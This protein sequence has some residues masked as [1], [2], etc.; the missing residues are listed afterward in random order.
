MVTKNGTSSND[1]LVGGNNTADIINGFG[2]NDTL[3]GLGQADALNGG[4]G[5]DALIGGA[6]ADTLDGGAGTDEI[7]YSSD[8]GTRGVTVNL[9]A[10]TAIDTFGTPDLIRGIERIYGSNR[11]DV[12]TGRDG[13]GDLLFGRGGN[14]AI[15]GGSGNDTLV[16]GAGKD[17]LDGGTGASDQVAYFLEG[18]T[19][20]VTV[21]LSAG[22]AIDTFGNADVLIGIEKVYGSNADDVFLGDTRDNLILGRSGADNLNGAGGA[23]TLVG[24]AGADTINGGDGLDQLAYFLE[25]GTRGISVNLNTGLAYDTFGDLDTLINVEY[26]FATD[27]DDTLIGSNR[28]KNDRLFGRDGNDVIDGLDGDNLI[29]TGAGNDT[30]RVGTTV[31]D[32]RDTVVIDGRGTKT[33]TGTGSEGTRYGHHIVFRTDSAVTV[34]LAT[35]IATSEGMRTDFSGALYFLEVNGSAYD[36]LLTGGN[37]RHQELEWYVGF[38]GNDTING[39][40]GTGDTVVYDDEVLIGQVNYATGLLERGTQG[41]IVNLSTGVATDTFGDTDTLINIDQ[42]RGTS[43]VDRI[44][45]SA[46]NNDFWGLRGADIFDGGAGDDFV[47]Y[48]EDY[49]AE[50]GDN[51]IVAD[52]AAGEVIDGFG[53]VD[54]LTS[55]EGVHGTDF[56]DAIR[57]NGAENRLVAYAGNDTVSGAGGDD[58]ILAGEGN[59]VINGGAGDDEIWGEEGNDTIDGAGGRDVARYL[60][61]TGPVNGNL[62]T[63]VVRDGHGTTD[64]LINVEDLHAS[65]NNDSVVG[66]SAENRLF[67]FGGNDTILGQGGEDVILGGEGADSLSGGAGDDEI[68]GE[69]GNDTIDGGD[70]SDLVRYREDARGVTVNLATDTAT[71]GSGA[72]DTMRNIENVHGSDHADAITGNA[73]DNRLFGFSGADSIAGGAGDDILLGGDGSDSLSGG[74]GNDQLWGE[75][76]TDTLD[77]GAGDGDVVRY[78]NSTAAVEVDL[79]AGTASDGLGY[80]DTLLNIEYAHGSDFGDLLRGNS[81]AN[82]LFG[83]DG[84]DTLIGGEGDGDL[85]SGGAGGDTYIYHAGDGRDTFNDLGETSGGADTVIIEGYTVENA[86]I[87]KQG[88]DALLI[89]FGTTNDSVALSFSYAGTHAGAI[90]Q[91]V[92]A[93]G[94]S[95]TIAQLKARIGTAL[96]QARNA[97]TNGDDALSVTADNT[98]VDGLAGDDTIAGRSSDDMLTGGAGNDVLR[99][100]AGDDTLEGGAGNDNMTGGDG[101][102]LFVLGTRMGSDTVRDF[103]FGKDGLDVSGLS[104]AQVSEIVTT[105][106]AG[107]Q[108]VVLP[109]GG[110]ITLLG[111]IGA[112][113]DNLVVTGAATED[114]TLT[115]TL[116]GATDLYGQ[117]PSNVTYQWQ[118]DGQ[119]ISGATGDSYVLTQADT[120]SQITVRVA[121]DGNAL[122]SAPTAA[123]ENLNDAPLGA[124]VI[125]GTVTEDQTLS[126]ST[127]DISDEDGLGTFSYHWVR[128]GLP[129]ESAVGPEYT[130]TQED[131]GNFVTVEITY[132]DG[133]GKA[134]KLVSNQSGPVANVNDPA[135]GS[136]ILNGDLLLGETLTLDPA[137]ADDD[138]I[139]TISYQW[140]H[141]GVAVSG[142]TGTSYTLGAADVEKQLSVRGTFTD[143]YG[144]AEQVRSSTV[145]LLR[146]ATAVEPEEPEEPVMSE[147]PDTGLRLFGDAGDNTLRG[148]EGNDRLSGAGGNDRLLGNGGADTLLGGDGADTLNGGDGNDEITGGA[149]END[150]RDVIFG[151]NGN[152]LIDAGY[153]NDNISGGNGNDTIAG[154]FGSDTVEGQGGDDVLTGSAFGDEIYGNGGDDFI[155]GGFGYDRVNGGAGAD[156][157]YHLGIADHGSDWIQ[158]YSSAEGDVLYYGG[159]ATAQQFLVQRT[160]TPNAGAGNVEEVFITHRPSGNLLWALI[161][162]DGEAELNIRIGT[163]VFDLLA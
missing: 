70:G 144:T 149:S 7:L 116:N 59:D 22:T 130:L 152:D 57:G 157:F 54:Q 96:V 15:N 24:G 58:I 108:E 27:L 25:T 33:I 98:T 41:A 36:D 68:W 20:G 10:G 105:T 82:N 81:Q 4:P 66:S 11:N 136:L 18:G 134:E 117:A 151:G 97:A 8:G 119:A 78:L 46:E 86:S 1:S 32:A 12:I 71:D 127:A 118:R 35:G 31:E 60:K 128:G 84:N 90:E 61:A 73:D 49:L 154:G 80:T 106:V 55:I 159:Q 141:D 156:Q 122:T 138:G 107:G 133:Q 47:H 112:G 142:Q 162:G 5:N 53:S 139:G 42:V 56:A 48:G 37:L 163:D 160:N 155:N 153:G 121:Y 143:G 104:T 30:V 110:S 52:L 72:T 140:Y 158:D 87:M 23:D 88:A 126:V 125:N 34:N 75:I 102:D 65:S 26:V 79:L 100:G 21:D 28:I 137:I 38:Q 74:D 145:K 77:G 76:G 67:G 62:T 113:A 150:R 114:A 14:D 89:D 135:T 115:V 120:G 69:A 99:G 6:G 39:G 51:G 40:T 83:Y 93:D 3:I 2:G 17:T 101:A 29:F 123:I 103:E 95:F 63:G 85:L 13:A 109:D 161:D 45:G 91:V 129:I 148:E 19:R 16:G 50:G 44:T 146:T 147:G 94:Q 131:V 64:M 111:N 132:T 43:F 9:Q 124:L 92:F